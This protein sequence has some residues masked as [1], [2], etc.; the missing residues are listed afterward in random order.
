MTA[1]TEASAYG[2]AYT[3]LLGEL[4]EEL[5][6][7]GNLGRPARRV[8]NAR[9]DGMRRG[10]LAIL[11]ADHFMTEDYAASVILTHAGSYCE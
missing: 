4:V 3:R 7:S 11:Q 1:E 6:R 10:L 2:R 8:A 5:R 9:I